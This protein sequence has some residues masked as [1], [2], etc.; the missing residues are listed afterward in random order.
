MKRVER[1]EERHEWIKLKGRERLRMGEEERK[2]K[3][4][5]RTETKRTEREREV[6]AGEVREERGEEVD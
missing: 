6:M 4:K 3:Y 2:Q 1:R 5:V